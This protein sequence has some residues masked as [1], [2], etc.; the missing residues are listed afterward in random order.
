MKDDVLALAYPIS[1]GPACWIG[2]RVA[3]DG[4]SCLT[5]WWRTI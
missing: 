3:H 1:F 5:T 4:T 2:S